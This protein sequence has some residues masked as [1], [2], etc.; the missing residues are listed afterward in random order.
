MN[1]Y[2]VCSKAM[3]KGHINVS[4][5]STEKVGKEKSGKDHSFKVTVDGEDLY[6]ACSNDK[7]ID[8]WVD[9]I[10]YCSKKVLLSPR[11]RADSISDKDIYLDSPTKK[12]KNVKSSNAFEASGNDD[13]EKEVNDKLK[14]NIDLEDVNIEMENSILSPTFVDEEADMDD[15]EEPLSTNLSIK[16]ISSDGSAIAMPNFNEMVR[17]LPSSEIDDP[18][19]HNEKYDCDKREQSMSADSAMEENMIGPSEDEFPPLEE[20]FQNILVQASDF[21]IDMKLGVCGT[22]A[23][24]TVYKAIRKSDNKI[25]ALKFFG[26]AK[27]DPENLDILGTE[28][29]VMLKL[30]G[31]EVFAQIESF[32]YDTYEG[33]IPHK[34]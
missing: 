25:F 29:D 7:D 5:A 20:R 21:I 17:G 28:I 1:I 6:L 10:S 12:K 26:Y 24:G 8:M 15:E 3:K 19:P 16:I 9:A 18:P 33:L 2:G 4:Q 13:N 27:R 32:F 23:F 34:K 11:R 31:S 30:K 22:G 14:V